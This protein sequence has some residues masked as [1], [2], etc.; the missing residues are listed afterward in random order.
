MQV[1]YSRYFDAVPVTGIN[2]GIFELGGNKGGG[3]LKQFLYLLFPTR[4]FA[5]EQVLQRDRFKW[6]SSSPKGELVIAFKDLSVSI[7]QGGPR[8]QPGAIRYHWAIRK[9]ISDLL[10]DLIVCDRNWVGT[11]GFRTKI[12]SASIRRIVSS[13]VPFATGFSARGFKSVIEK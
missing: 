7:N 3:V 6:R 2:R 1:L 4:A 8:G 5:L 12:H 11:E 9:A 13:T 10:S